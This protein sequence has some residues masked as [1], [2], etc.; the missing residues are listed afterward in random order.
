MSRLVRASLWGTRARAR[1]FVFH[2]GSVT[3]KI[4]SKGRREAEED[5][6]EEADGSISG[7]CKQISVIHHRDVFR[8]TLTSRAPPHAAYRSQ[9]AAVPFGRL[10]Q[11]STT[12]G[13][14]LKLVFRSFVFNPL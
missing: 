2:L 9:H 12:T 4:S 5:S 7:P 11:Q 1:C 3:W 13:Q 8:L 10:Q 14:R 6:P